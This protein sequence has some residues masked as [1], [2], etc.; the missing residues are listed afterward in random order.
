MAKTEDTAHAKRGNAPEEASSGR[1]QSPEKPVYE[2][3]RLRR[4]DQIDQ[5]KPYGPSEL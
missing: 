3:P 1:G 2:K 5:V 4:Y